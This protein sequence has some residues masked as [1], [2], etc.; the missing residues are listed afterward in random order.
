M[1]LAEMVRLFSLERLGRRRRVSI[2]RI[3]SGITGSTC[4]RPERTASSTSRPFGSPPRPRA[5][6]RARPC[7]CRAAAPPRAVAALASTATTRPTRR[8]RPQEVREAGE[9]AAPRTFSRRV[10]RRDAVR[11]RYPGE[12]AA[13]CGGRWV[14]LGALAQPVRLALT[15]S[16]ASPP[17][18]ELI[19]VLDGRRPS[20]ESWPSP[21]GSRRGRP[22]ET[23]ERHRDVPPRPEA[24]VRTSSARSWTRP[25]QRKARRPG[26]DPVPARTERLPPPWARQ[27]DC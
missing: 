25:P 18:F 11:A 4:R 12:E 9:R 22:E 8:R 24:P 15:G 1:S 17:L 13:A 26:G 16:L 27:V 6:V 20:G 23:H 5:P 19:D 10:L 3:S 14:S 7:T 2:T 21:R